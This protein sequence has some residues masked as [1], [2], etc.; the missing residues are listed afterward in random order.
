MD[1]TLNE[2]EPYFTNLYLQGEFNK[3]KIRKMFCLIGITLLPLSEDPPCS[4][5]SSS[6]HIP[7]S[8]PKSVPRPELLN[9]TEP[10]LERPHENRFCAWKCEIPQQQ[11]IYEEE[12]G[13]S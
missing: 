5:V 3:G 1:V 7:Q 10:V 8:Q 2:Q 12:D 9:E 6:N 4:S 11:G 13:C